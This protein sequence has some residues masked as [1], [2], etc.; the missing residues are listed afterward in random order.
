MYYIVGQ[1]RLLIAEKAIR[2]DGFLH[3]NPPC[4]G[5]IIFDDEI[6]CGDEILIRRER[7]AKR[8]T[9]SFSGSVCF[10]F[11]T[12]GKLK[13]V[14]WSYKTAVNRRVTNLHVSMVDIVDKMLYD[15]ITGPGKMKG[16]SL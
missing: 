9:I 2:K 3:R 4:G 15:I 12:E 6:S 1:F 8:R 16:D 5:G 7:S 13:K 11:P 10:T 14:P